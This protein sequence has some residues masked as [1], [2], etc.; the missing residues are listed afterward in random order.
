MTENTSSNN[1]LEV[2]FF[3][4]QGFAVCLGNRAVSASFRTEAEATRRLA[5]LEEE[6]LLS[7]LA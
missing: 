2:R 6:G 1:E 5:E 3:G 7:R 4:L